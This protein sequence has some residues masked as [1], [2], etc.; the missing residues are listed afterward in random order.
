[1]LESC[2]LKL[3]PLAFLPLHPLI[4][5]RS[6]ALLKPS[7][8]PSS[9]L[10]CASLPPNPSHVPHLTRRSLLTTAIST[11][12]A[13]SLATYA[14]QNALCAPAAITAARSALDACDEKITNAKWDGVRTVIASGALVSMKKTIG[15]TAKLLPDDLRG[16]Y[17]GF[18]EDLL[19]ALK[20]LDG[21]VY[22][23]V[24][25]GEDRQILGTKID[26]DTPRVY[27]QDAKDALDAMIEIADEG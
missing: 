4:P 10:T 11:L 15:E 21:A 2:Q 7:S 25:I 22:G 12:A 27:L 13:A 26:Y 20:L 19:T 14:P 16:P 3:N 18:G 1:M 6:P 24:F 23:N 9:S 5:L 8:S 17:V